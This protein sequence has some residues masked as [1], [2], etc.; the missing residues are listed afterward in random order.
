MPK[1]CRKCAEDGK[2]LPTPI[3]K[4]DSYLQKM[5]PKGSIKHDYALRRN[6]AYN[7]QYLQYLRQSLNEFELTS[8]ILTQTWKVFIIVGTGIVE[9]LL[10]FAVSSNGFQK[11]TY[12]HNVANTSTNEFKIDGVYHKI[13]HT[14][15]VKKD[16]AL[17]ENMTLEWMIKKAQKEKLLGNDNSIYPRLKTLRRLRNR[18]HLQEIQEERDTDYNQF[19]DEHIY[20]V[21]R[22]LYAIMTGD[23][24][25]PT[26]SEKE[27]FSFLDSQ[28]DA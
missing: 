27:I 12:W 15:L 20:T 11:E 8:V 19:T 5:I 25:S 21:L 6:I 10:Y 14:I 1:V 17:H 16:A 22:T 13:E 18:V 2:W 7:L 3:T 26:K 4:L 28:D 24:F 9:A 23:L